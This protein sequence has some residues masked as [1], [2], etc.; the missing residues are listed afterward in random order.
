MS[1]IWTLDFEEALAEWLRRKKWREASCFVVAAVVI[2][3]YL[4]SHLQFLD[5]YFLW[6]AEFY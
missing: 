1:F 2:V 5:K 6:T 3:T 4:H